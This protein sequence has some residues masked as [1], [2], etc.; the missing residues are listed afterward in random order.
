MNRKILFA[1][2]FTLIMLVNPIPSYPMSNCWKVDR[3]PPPTLIFI[4]LLPLRSVVSMCQQPASIVG[5]PIAAI[6][7]R[8]LI[9]AEPAKPTPIFC[10]ASGV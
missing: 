9:R 8:V 6:F 5:N 7:R 10:M 3:R 1:L 2:M 4:V